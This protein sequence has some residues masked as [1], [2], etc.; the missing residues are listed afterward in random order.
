MNKK[1]LTKQPTQLER[2]SNSC[3]AFC[4]DNQFISDNNYLFIA[5]KRDFCRV[6]FNR[7]YLTQL[8]NEIKNAHLHN[9]VLSLAIKL[10]DTYDNELWQAYTVVDQ[11]HVLSFE[12]IPYEDCPVCA[13]KE[14]YSKAEATILYKKLFDQK[15]IPNIKT[16]T[17]QVFSFGFAKKIPST[18]N[19]GLPNHQFDKLL[20]DNF[21]AKSVFRMVAADS[22]YADD[23]AIGIDQDLELAELKSL[24]EYLERY[25]FMMQICRF[26][27]KQYDDQIIMSYLALYNKIATETELQNIRN[28]ACWGINLSTEE[29][30]AIPLS[31]IF[32]RG[33]V[34]FI[35]PTSS[36]FGAHTDFKK[37]LCSSIL[38]LVER[39]AFMRFWHDPQRAFNLDTDE[40]VKSS[41]D[42]IISILKPA[43]NNETLVS[44]VFVIQ[45]PTKLPVILITIT[46]N[47]FSKPPSLCFGCGVGFD[48][49]I[50]L[51]GALE[52]LR[53]NTINLIKGITF[54]DGFFDRQFTTNIESI[55]D[56]MNFYST[57]APREKLKF[58]DIVNPLIDGIVEEEAQQDLKSIIN[59][60]E[61]I[62]FDIYGI[63]C[64]PRCFSDKNIYVTRAFSP[65]LYPLQFEQEDTL[66]IATTPL[67]ACEELPHF[68]L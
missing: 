13:K 49:N 42:E 31:F 51:H 50:A 54:I 23:S 59:R 35:L 2:V 15:S 10:D 46:S 14:N 60:F 67:S 56:R 17:K 68:F 19:A 12:L 44:N 58:L 4:L 38:E 29:I 26:K 16:L 37:S 5:P 11:K 36:G 9:N 53:Q 34:D 63:D 22:R 48:I 45:S 3:L 43:V 55:P 30:C 25:A 41:L 61:I 40:E 28:D 6:C 7:R 64:T 1:Y 47:D 66:K 8:M 52:E 20:G 39:D 27:T 57:S 65:Q 21:V 32:N 33:Q 62:N 18:K 24:M